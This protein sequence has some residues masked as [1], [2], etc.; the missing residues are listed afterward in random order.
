[1]DTFTYDG[2]YPAGAVPVRISS[3]RPAWKWCKAH[4]ARATLLFGTVALGIA[5]ALRRHRPSQSRSL[6]LGSEVPQAIT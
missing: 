3:F 5:L 1:M 4:P 2:S 6:E